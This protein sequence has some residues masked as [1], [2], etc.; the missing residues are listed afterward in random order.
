MM[1]SKVLF[2][3]WLLLLVTTQSDVK[4]A[5]PAHPS[6][7]WFKRKP[8][9]TVPIHGHFLSFG[10]KNQ[11]PQPSP[12]QLFRLR[13]GREM[14]MQVIPEDVREDLKIRTLL[15]LKRVDAVKGLLELTAAPPHLLS[16]IP[17]V[18]REF[19]IFEARHAFFSTRTGSRDS[20][21]LTKPE[22]KYRPPHMRDGAMPCVPIKLDFI[23]EKSPKSV[24]YMLST[25]DHI[26]FFYLPQ[27]V[28][29]DLGIDEVGALQRKG[30]FPEIYKRLFPDPEALSSFVSPSYSDSS[31][32]QLEEEYI[33]DVVEHVG[34]IDG[35][36]DSQFK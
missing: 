5:A 14:V 25:M 1:K 2:L 7:Q 34:E 9:P 35:Y 18:K 36:F 10:L 11:T 32:S 12:H 22:A 8:Q 31:I 15:D 30:L 23:S 13:R 20:F 28:K 24:S 27:E 19:P 4:S 17:G 26:L 21:V 33:D 6:Q 3:P 16:T 29:D